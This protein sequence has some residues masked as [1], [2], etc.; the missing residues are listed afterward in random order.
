MSRKEAPGLAASLAV[1]L[2]VSIVVFQAG[3]GTFDLVPAD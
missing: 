1:T 3:H 2:T